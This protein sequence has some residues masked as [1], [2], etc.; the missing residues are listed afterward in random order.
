MIT[1]DPESAPAQPARRARAARARVPFRPE[2]ER[3]RIAAQLLVALVLAILAQLAVAENPAVIDGLLLFIV[4]AVVFVWALERDRSRPWPEAEQLPLPATAEPTRAPWRSL[5][6]APQLIALVGV[7]A[8]GAIAWMAFGG[9]R[10]TMTN[11]SLWLAALAL[12]AGAFVEWP[13]V[14]LRAFYRRLTRPGDLVVRVSPTVLAVAGIVLVAIFFRFH[15]LDRTPFAMVSDHAEK[16]LDVNDILHG[17]LS[18]FFPRNTGREAFQFY[19]I[20]GTVELLDLPLG[21]TAMKIG[22]AAFGVFTIPWIY[23][24]GKELFSRRVGLI[25]A[26]LVA[27]SLWAEVVS[28]IGLRYPFTPAFGAPTLFFLVR[29]FKYNRRNDW[30]LCGLFLGLGLHT[31]TPFRVMPILLVALVVVKLLF[32]LARQRFGAAAVDRDPTAPAAS[33]TTSLTPAF[34]V[35]AVLAGILAAL[36]FLPL[37]R[38]AVDQPSIF[39]LR[40]LTRSSGIERDVA[41]IPVLTF[42]EN[43]KNALLMFNY[44]GDVSFISNVPGDRAVDI[45]TGG[46]MVLGFAYVLW[47]L[48]RYRDRTSLYL[49]AMLFLLLFPSTSNTAFPI[50]NPSVVR[51]SGALAVVFF[52]AAMPLSLAAT[53][54]HGALSGLPRLAPY[55]TVAAALLVAVPLLIAA[56]LNYDWFFYRYDTSYRATIGNEAEMG[57]VLRGFA[58]SVGDLQHAYLVAAPFWVDARLVGITTGD[59]TWANVIETNQIANTARDRNS[60]LFLVNTNDSASLEKL[61]E[62]FPSG[63]VNRYHSKIGRD[64]MVFLAPAQT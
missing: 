22:T 17:Q 37:G 4:A 36:V 43:N 54:L 18:V 55:R 10:F 38:F 19:L 5:V 2:L 30:L 44:R 23:L 60:K 31:Y 12:F 35:N 57:S 7:L 16:L 61:R 15:D 63:S 49:L 8:V 29:G 1:S 59:V 33:E 56:R 53:R 25:A 9:N 51:A 62:V 24:L 13:E 47:R 21:H 40:A 41:G 45:V 6:R 64:F 50:E 28:R 20:A 14:D 11:V 32:D 46:L 34:W 27:V 58:D 3:T 48:V 26:A 42:L 52:F 39:W